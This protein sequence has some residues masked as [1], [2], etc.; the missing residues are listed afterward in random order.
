VKGTI[1][2]YCNGRQNQRA[3]EHAPRFSCLSRGLSYTSISEGVQQE[4]TIQN[5]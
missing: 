5:D 4:L 2:G 3:L 1:K